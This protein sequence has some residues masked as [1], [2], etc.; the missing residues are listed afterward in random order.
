M[1][2]SIA[3]VALVT[4]AFVSLATTDEGMGL[5]Y[6]CPLHHFDG[7]EG[8]PYAWVKSFLKEIKKR[9]P[10]L[11]TTPKVTK[12]PNT[13][14][15][16]STKASTT[17]THQQT[18][19]TNSLTKTTSP[20]TVTTNQPTMTAN[21]PTATTDPPS[22]TTDPPTTTTKPPTA[23]TEPPSATTNPPTTTTD[24]PT[25][26]TDQPTMTANPPTAT[27][28]PPS[29]T[30]DPPTTTTKPPT[31]T[32]EPPSATTN[33]P[34]TTTDPPTTT[35]DPPT[36]TTDPPTTTTDPPTTTTD[37]PTTTTAPQP[38]ITTSEAPTIAPTPPPGAA[39]DCQAL[40]DAGNTVSGVYTIY[41]T[42]Y[43]GGLEVRCDMTTDSKAWIVFQRRV[44]GTVSFI[45]SW[46]EYRDGFGDKEGSFWLGN[47]ILRRLTEPVDQEW[48]MRVNIVRNEA[49]RATDRFALYDQFRITG[50]LYSLSLVY[51]GAAYIQDSLSPPQAGNGHPF[52]TYDSDN[53]QDTGLNCADSLKGGWWFDTCGTESVDS[54]LYSN[55]NGEY[56]QGLTGSLAFVRGITWSKYAGFIFV[57]TDL[58][59]RRVS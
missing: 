14:T 17:T 37:P 35:T 4:V 12:P 55:L 47:E 28:D 27:T 13:S 43:P 32:T 3:L 29:T 49:T 25:T 31:A 8:S 57:E 1:S 40:L 6:R 51:S 36:T 58:K 52:T 41:P 30:T 53:D 48:Q 22:T 9:C 21:P 15:R 46:A 50:E 33:P 20:V 34:T 24:P 45:R 7:D 44:D 18:T 19:T 38:P 2:S 54:I 42:S 10:G 56:G 59:M 23:T 11:K 5:C 39:A 26:T 16:T